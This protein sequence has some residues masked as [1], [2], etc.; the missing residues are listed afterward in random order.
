M[1]G[2]LCNIGRSVLCTL[3]LLLEV[4]RLWNFYIK[5]ELTLIQSTTRGLESTALCS[6]S[7]TSWGCSIFGSK[8]DKEV[9]PEIRKIFSSNSHRCSTDKDLPLNKVINEILSPIIRLLTDCF[10]KSRISKHQS[11]LLLNTTYASKFF[12]NHHQKLFLLQLYF[13]L[14]F[15][16][17]EFHINNHEV[18][19]LPDASGVRGRNEEDVWLRNQKWRIRSHNYHL[20]LKSD[21]FWTK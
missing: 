4:L 19:V 5:M 16:R 18:A 15:C 13:S 2:V 11:G 10:D 1:V 3:L 21:I 14:L 12:K 20:W 7:W 8:D 6:L 17:Y 9:F